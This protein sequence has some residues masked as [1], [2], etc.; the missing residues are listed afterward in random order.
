M[1][2][3]ATSEHEADREG[4][5]AFSITLH[6]RRRASPGVAYGFCGVVGAVWV[7]VGLF[8]TQF[9]GMVIFGF[10]GAEFILIASMFHIYL[11]PPNVHE[12]IEITPQTV[13]VVRHDPRGLNTK[14]F[15][16]Y[17][18]QVNYPGSYMHDAAL[19]IRSHGEA[20]EIGQY[21]S[22]LDK[23][24]TAMRLN[25]VLARLRTTGSLA[26]NSQDDA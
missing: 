26:E 24:R 5:Q 12:T 18:A 10:F 15:P 2:I 25:D 20:I 1:N 17:W 14:A 8:F 16:A 23:A 21:L 6:T 9:G 7:M 4:R 22:P 13:H 3:R 11:G 19:E